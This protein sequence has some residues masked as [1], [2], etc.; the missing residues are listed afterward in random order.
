MLVSERDDAGNERARSRTELRRDQPSL[1]VLL[2]SGSTDARVLTGLGSGPTAFLAKPFK[3]SDVL[4]SVRGLLVAEVH[5][6]A[7]DLSRTG[8]G[9]SAG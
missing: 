6:E 4:A 2:V 8:G 9:D 3:P 7:P 1:G 5:A